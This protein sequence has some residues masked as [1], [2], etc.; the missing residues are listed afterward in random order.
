[1]SEYKTEPYEDV[2]NPQ[3]TFHKL[4]I[5]GVCHFDEFLTTI[6]KNAADKKLFNYIIQYM[7]G[8]TDQNR[9][10]A[11]KFNH[12][13]DDNRSD[14]FEFKKDRLRVYVIKQKPNFFIVLG[15]YKGKQKKDIKVLKSLIKDFPKEYEL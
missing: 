7:D 15:G 3:Y 10:P 8:I 9:Y 12:I 11:T 14:I 6:E 1:M 13:E 4:Y 2:D 5:D